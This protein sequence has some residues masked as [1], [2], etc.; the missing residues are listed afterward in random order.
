MRFF[1]RYSEA[2]GREI[3]LISRPVDQRHRIEA[4]QTGGLR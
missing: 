4:E 1:R 2:S 3:A